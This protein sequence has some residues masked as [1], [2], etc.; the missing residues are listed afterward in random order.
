MDKEMHIWETDKDIFTKLVFAPGSR[1]TAF[2]R[3]PKVPAMSAVGTQKGE[4][5][6]FNVEDGQK[7]KLPV[8]DGPIQDVGFDPKS[9]D[10]LLVATAGWL[11]RTSTRPSNCSSSSSSS[12]AFSSYYKVCPV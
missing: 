9:E 8:F 6:L 1:I 12:S 2:V 10:Y 7:E 3:H 11:L 5:F 4:V